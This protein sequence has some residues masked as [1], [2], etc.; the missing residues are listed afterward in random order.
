MGVREEEG[1]EEM[2]EKMED[3]AEKKK[4]SRMR[5]Y[6]SVVIESNSKVTRNWRN[7]AKQIS[8]IYKWIMMNSYTVFLSYCSE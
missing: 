8:R 1:I 4:W 7:V 6:H 2:E 5:R 3:E